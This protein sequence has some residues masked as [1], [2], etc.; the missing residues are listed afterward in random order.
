MGRKGRSNAD[1]RLL[2][3]DP[4]ALLQEM[5]LGIGQAANVSGVSVRQLAY[6]TDKGYFSPAGRGKSRAYDWPAIEKANLIKQVLDQGCTLAA[7]AAAAEEF[8]RIRDEERMRVRGL[9]GARLQQYLLQQAEL[10]QRAAGR[11]REQVTMARSSRLGQLTLAFS[12]M[13][14]LLRFLQSNLRTATTADEIA[15]RLGQPIKQVEAQ[16]A[17]LEKRRLVQRLRYPGSEVWRYTPQRAA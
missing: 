11:V 1:P 9:S 2:P 15:A 16:L 14:T 12:G 10:L 3:T 5:V 4:C 7:A 8:L 13:E 17:V 6:W